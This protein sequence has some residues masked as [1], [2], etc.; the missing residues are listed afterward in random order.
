MFYIL[1]ALQWY[2]LLVGLRIDW[3]VFN[4]CSHETLLHIGPS[5]PLQSI[6]YYHQDLHWWR[7]QVGPRPDPSTHTTTTLLLSSISR[8]YQVYLCIELVGYGHDA[9]APSIFRASCFG[10][11]VV[12]HS[13]ADSD[14]HGHRPAVLSNQRLSWDLMSVDSG[15]LTQRLVHP[16]APVLLTKSGPLGTLHPII[17]LCFDQASQTSH[18]FK[19]WE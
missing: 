9:S 3:L 5:G 1:I 13:L 4:G 18:P 15:A 10:R 7:L 11:W 12:T 6:C 19:V 17:C 16:T 14:F 2:R 8:I